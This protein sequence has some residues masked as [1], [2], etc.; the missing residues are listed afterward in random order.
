MKP[1]KVDYDSS[2][3]RWGEEFKLIGA[4]SRHTRRIIKKYMENL[5]YKSIIDVGCATGIFLNSLDLKGKSVAGV[6]ISNA[7]INICKKKMPQGDFR[8]MD[9]GKRKLNKKYDLGICSEVLEHIDDDI[10]ALSNLKAMCKSIIITVPSGKYGEDDKVQGH[11]RRYSKKEMMLK[12]RKVGFKVVRIENWGFPFYSPFY[13]FVINRVHH[14][15]RVGMKLSGSKK[16]VSHLLYCLF[17]FN[18]PG[19][20]DRLFVLAE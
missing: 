16:I 17:F 2:W 6:D 20:G 1:Y 9:I 10:K 11:Y 3:D 19:Y 15:D 13:R 18:V 4:S 14:D 5:T 12:L 8:V 7:G